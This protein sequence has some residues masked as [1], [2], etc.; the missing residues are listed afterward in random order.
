MR[1]SPDGKRDVVDMR[2]PITGSRSRIVIISGLGLPPKIGIGAVDLPDETWLE[3]ENRFPGAS[4]LRY[5]TVE[6]LHGGM[7]ALDDLE[8]DGRVKKGEHHWAARS[9][10]TF[11][12]G[13][14]DRPHP[15]PGVIE[16]GS[17]TP[18]DRA[19]WIV[20]TADG[21]SLLVA[22][23]E[24]DSFEIRDVIAKQIHGEFIVEMISAG[25]LCAV[26]NL[27]VPGWK[28]IK[29]QTYTAMPQF[30]C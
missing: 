10:A 2:V 19:A 15:K 7:V 6:T 16:D 9:G 12:M 14:L 25:S 24:L 22:P 1:K 20:T 27:A 3:M 5:D 13:L 26:E 18:T 21:R 8:D 17:M 30:R 28:A 4:N 23:Y 11:G 29:E